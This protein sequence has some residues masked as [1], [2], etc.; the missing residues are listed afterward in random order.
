MAMVLLN[1]SWLHLGVLRRVMSMINENDQVDR[2]ISKAK[3]HALLHVHT[4]PINVVVFHG[5][6]REYSFS[7]GFPA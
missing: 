1:T 2:A 6:D 4:P 5:P 7:G 3:L